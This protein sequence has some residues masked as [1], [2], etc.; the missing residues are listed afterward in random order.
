MCKKKNR[1]IPT[2]KILFLGT[3]RQ[4]LEKVYIDIL[5]NNETYPRIRLME[6]LLECLAVHSQ[7]IL[8]SSS[9]TKLCI[10]LKLTLCFVIR[11]Q[12]CLRNV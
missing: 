12:K 6:G 10:S 9:K 11:Q 2:V 4:S 7:K 3:E 5:A 1:G 8:F